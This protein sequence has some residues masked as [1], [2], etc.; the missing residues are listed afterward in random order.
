[1]N[2]ST[3]TTTP[4]S[5]APP[6]SKSKEG[7][8]GDQDEV[9]FVSETLGTP[10]KLTS[11]FPEIPSLAVDKGGHSTQGSPSVSKKVGKKEEKH[12]DT[13][14]LADVAKKRGK[15]RARTLTKSGE[16]E[17]EIS[18]DLKAATKLED[19]RC[20]SGSGSG[21]GS[22]SPSK[23]FVFPAR[24]CDFLASHLTPLAPLL[25]VEKRIEVTFLVDKLSGRPYAFVST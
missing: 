9:T 11:V 10:N 8:D 12:Q 4:V 6:A 2:R 23:K 24:S 15:K 18:A 16:E 17:G 14:I 21:S 5:P 7:G 3:S 1:M 25:C 22:G 20:C 19:V 13:G